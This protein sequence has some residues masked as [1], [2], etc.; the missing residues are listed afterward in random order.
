MSVVIILA[1]FVT[2]GGLKTLKLHLVELYVGTTLFTTESK[3][4]LTFVC[5]RLS[6]ST[7]LINLISTT[8]K[9]KVILDEF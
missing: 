6:D 3:H 1:S 2:L 9:I 7:L 4:E 8:L 5:P